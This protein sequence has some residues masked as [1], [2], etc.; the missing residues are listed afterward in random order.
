MSFPN[1]AQSFVDAKTHQVVEPWFSLLVG[2]F[3]R[4]EQRGGIDV[5]KVGNQAVGWSNATPTSG[6]WRAGDVLFDP[7][8]TVGQPYL[9]IC[10]V[11]GEPGTW[12]TGANL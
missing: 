2:F 11:S 3:Q 5:L 12:S 10:T 6:A 8:P 4:R 1:I 7:S 9:R